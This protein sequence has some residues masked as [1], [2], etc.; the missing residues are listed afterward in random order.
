[1]YNI[2]YD[3]NIAVTAKEWHQM[4]NPVTGSKPKDKTEAEKEARDP[5]PGNAKEKQEQANRA[6]KR[7][8][9]GPGQTIEPNPPGVKP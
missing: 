7:E 1:L 3:N 5:Q 6:Q 9:S 8:Q 4:G 2:V